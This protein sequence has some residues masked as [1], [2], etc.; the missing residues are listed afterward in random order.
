MVICQEVYFQ[1]KIMKNIY[2]YMAE[3]GGHF[4]YEDPNLDHDIDHDGDNDEQEV[5]TTRPFQPGASSTPY[6]GGE[7]HEMQSRLHEQSSGRPS[8][9]ETSF[10]GN[11]RTPLIDPLEDRFRRFKSNPVTGI[12]DTTSVP[13][14]KINLLSDEEKNQQIERVKRFIRSRFPNTNFKGLVIGYSSK[15]NPYS[16]VVKGPRGGETPILLSDSSDFQQSFLSQTYVKNA[17]GRPS[18]SIIGQAS[19]DIRK[20]QKDL[21]QLRQDQKRYREQ[22]EQKE[23]KELDLQRRIRTEEEK[24]QQLQDDPDADKKVLEQ[25]DALIK[26][27]KKDLKTKK[28]EN[29][30]LEKI[31]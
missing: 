10:G 25:K 11:E 14:A 27:L 6:H 5:D 1:L 12:F 18:E 22:K 16:L 20:K 24:Q 4:G 7:Q 31:M 23:K 15:K 21:S 8:Y 26:N 17:L 30:Q 29:A 13:N 3:G 2:I 28:K 19:A 9:E